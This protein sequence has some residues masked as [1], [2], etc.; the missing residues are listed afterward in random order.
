MLVRI[1][2]YTSTLKYPL[3]RSSFT[4][5]R[6]YTILELRNF[7]L[8]RTS[9]PGTFIWFWIPPRHSLKA[10]LAVILLMVRQ[11]IHSWGRS[12]K[13][14][15]SVTQTSRSMSFFLDVHP[16]RKKKMIWPSFKQQNINERPRFI[17]VSKKEQFSIVYKNTLFSWSINVTLGLEQFAS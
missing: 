14:A 17:Q 15:F 9:S 5:E 6:K 10:D 12:M 13:P 2:F 1:L 3:G 11:V 7:R 8:L 4:L 16:W